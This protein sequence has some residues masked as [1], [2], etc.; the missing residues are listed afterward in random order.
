M[1]KTILALALASTAVYGGWRVLHHSSSDAADTSSKLVFDRIWID[2]L[3]RNDK[4]TVN[5]FV[6]LHEDAMGIFQAT[7]QWRGEYEVFQ[8][9]ATGKE[10]R[11]VY[12]HSGDKE[13]VKIKATECNDQRDMDYCLEISGN[14]RGVEHY[15]SREGWEVGSVSNALD[16]EGKL[17]GTSSR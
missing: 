16:L 17:F 8:F 14:S 10:M 7:S 11:I 13:R 3:P 4:D 2:H 12:P 1:K 6:A 5:L 9:E 15:Y